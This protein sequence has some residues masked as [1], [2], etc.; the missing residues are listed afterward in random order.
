MELAHL[1]KNENYELFHFSEVISENKLEFDHKLKKGILKT[2][3]AIKILEIYGYPSQ[4]IN[5]ARNVE[6]ILN[7]QNILSEN[8]QT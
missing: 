2:K 8:F 4:I 7:R 5:D 6:N 1:L 3:N